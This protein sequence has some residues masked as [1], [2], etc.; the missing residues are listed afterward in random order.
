[1]MKMSYFNGGDRLCWKISNLHEP[2]KITC[3][4]FAQINAD[5]TLCYVILARHQNGDY[6]NG[7]NLLIICENP[8]SSVAQMGFLG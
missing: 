5:E 7:R 4:R 1:M 3:H 8:R 6:K 2:K